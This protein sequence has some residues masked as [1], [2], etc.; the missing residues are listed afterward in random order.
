M[1]A[2]GQGAY[3][4][5]GVK[6]TLQGEQYELEKSTDSYDGSPAVPPGAGEGVAGGL[7]RRGSQVWRWLLDQV[8][9]PAPT[10][11]GARAP[12]AVPSSSSSNSYVSSNNPQVAPSISPAPAP[13]EAP[14]PSPAPAD[15]DCA[16]VG[17]VRVRMRVRVRR[18]LTMLPNSP[19][20]TCY[21]QRT[22]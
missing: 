16:F 7:R 9:A 10:P 20:T 4:C 19:F 12:A 15:T 3:T 22:H 21:N 1:Q 11:T 14:S 5:S 17:K 2:V 6:G 13:Q 8:A 18:G